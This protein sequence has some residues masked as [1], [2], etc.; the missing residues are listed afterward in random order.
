MPC[1][2]D[3][4]VVGPDVAASQG[5]LEPR[6]GLAAI[7]VASVAGGIVQ[8]ALIRS[9]ARPALLRILGRVAA[10]DRLDREAS[11]S[12]AA[13]RA[14]W[15]W[16]ARRPD[17]DRRDRR[18]RPGGGRRRRRS[19]SGWPSA[20]PCSSARISAWASCSARRSCGWS[21][22]RGAD[23]DR[24]RRAR[25]RRRR[26]LVGARPAPSR[27]RGRAWRPDGPGGRRR[28]ATRGRRRVG[29]TPAALRACR[30]LR[31]RR[32]ARPRPT[33]PGRR[34]GAGRWRR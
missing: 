13:A 3:L 24:R 19:C 32:A 5:R 17:P 4:I 7:V 27:D 9:F 11:A 8:Y 29:V 15:R 25:D 14:P 16:P 31:S 23:R 33:D 2:V 22:R 30:S 1:P 18:E 34:R 6:H 28:R 26:R 12:D 20:T 10:A 21:A